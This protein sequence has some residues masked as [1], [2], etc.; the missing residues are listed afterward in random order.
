[1][2]EHKSENA[3]TELLAHLAARRIR[4]A[5][6]CDLI[7]LDGRGGCNEE[8]VAVRWDGA[9]ADVVCAEHAARDEERGDSF[10]Y[11]PKAVLL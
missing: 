1:M 4:D 10:V 2:S 7:G 11:R 6:S 3:R 8:P 5:A 9:F